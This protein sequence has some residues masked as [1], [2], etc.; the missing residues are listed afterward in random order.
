MLNL[1]VIEGQK[2]TLKGC[3]VCQL[4]IWQYVFSM[5]SK[6]F[7]IHSQLCLV[8][9]DL[10]KLG[11]ELNKIVIVDNSPASYLFHPRNAVSLLLMWNYFHLF[12]NLQH[13]AYKFYS[14]VNILSMQ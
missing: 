5:S 7:L 13:K 4:F 1:R 12:S 2:L 8:Y 3:S 11:R 9:Q 10:S 14:D 6:Y